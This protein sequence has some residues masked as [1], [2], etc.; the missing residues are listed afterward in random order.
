[1][2]LTLQIT[3][4]NVISFPSTYQFK[5]QKLFITEY[6]LLTVPN[7][8]PRDLNDHAL[9]SYYGMRGCFNS[10]L[11]RNFW[12]EYGIG[13]NPALRVIWAVAYFSVNT[14]LPN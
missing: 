14:N 4:C 7:P 13:T 6:F 5:L 1:M 8:W 10:Q 2:K 3:C 9:N 11:G 12:P